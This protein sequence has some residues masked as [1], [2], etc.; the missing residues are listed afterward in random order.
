MDSNDKNIERLIKANMKYALTICKKFLPDPE[1]ADLLRSYS[2]EKIW[3]HRETFTGTDA[4]FR[5]WMFII[6]KHGFI[7][8]YRK[9]KTQGYSMPIEDLYYHNHPTVESNVDIFEKAA[10]IRNISFTIDQEFSE[11]DA[12]IFK[13]NTFEGYKY[14]EVAEEMNV[15]MGTVKH[16]IHQ[17]RKYLLDPMNIR[18]A[19]DTNSTVVEPPLNHR[20]TNN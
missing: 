17:I 4:M 12:R 5:A 3:R 20:S 14:N 13:L 10:L 11:R 15:P 6:I 2:M 7:N 16:V 19:P 8:I 1:E 18:V 9:K